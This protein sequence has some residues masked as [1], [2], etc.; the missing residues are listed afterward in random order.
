MSSARNSSTS[1][2]IES[3][4]VATLS[5]IF[6]KRYISATS[7]LVA[8]L[9][10]SFATQTPYVFPVE[11]SRRQANSPFTAHF[12]FFFCF[13][14][15]YILIYI[16]IILS[17]SHS[18]S[19]STFPSLTFSFSYFFI[20]LI[21]S[22]FAS[23]FVAQD[24]PVGVRNVSVGVSQAG[25]RRLEPFLPRPRPSSAGKL[26]TVTKNRSRQETMRKE[27]IN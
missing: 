9:L 10:K 18:H 7:L 20:A 11:G 13:F 4:W 17:H 12:F 5:P 3:A 27:N 23:S 21:S 26:R 19:P 25:P 14:F 16:L 24:K 1:A 2:N 15:F 8:P 6:E 22:Y